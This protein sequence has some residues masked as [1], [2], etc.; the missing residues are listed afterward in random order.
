MRY[1]YSLLLQTDLAARD[2]SDFPHE[3]KKIEI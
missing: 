2:W 1:F 3:K